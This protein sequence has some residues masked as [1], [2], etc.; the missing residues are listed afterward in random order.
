MAF[1]FTHEDLDALDEIAVRGFLDNADVDRTL[2]RLARLEATLNAALRV[3]RE[4]RESQ[5]GDG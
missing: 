1:T 2:G 3:L 5:A 4:A